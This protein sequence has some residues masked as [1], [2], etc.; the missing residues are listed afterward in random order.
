MRIILTI[1]VLATCGIF[2]ANV[3]HA[4]EVPLEFKGLRIGTDL[5]TLEKAGLINC[6]KMVQN[7]RTELCTAKEAFFSSNYATFVG[8]PI[9]F[10]LIHALDRKIVRLFISP[11]TWNI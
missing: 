10:V 5:V 7:G 8:Q 9:K 6:R 1:W 11:S 2:V 3:T 4:T